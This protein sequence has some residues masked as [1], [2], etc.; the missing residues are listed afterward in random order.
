MKPVLAESATPDRAEALLRNDEWIAQQ[1][2]DGQRVLVTINDGNVQFLN[3]QGVAKQTNVTR[4][5]R[6]EFARF[7]IGEWAFDGEILD[8]VLWLFDMPRAGEHVD[9]TSPLA[10]RMSV[11]DGL[12]EQGIFTDSP[13]VRVLPRAETTDEKVALCE[14]VRDFGGEGLMLKNLNGRYEIGRR[15][16]HLLKYKFVNTCDAI[17]SRA[18]FDGKENLSLQ[19]Y[20]DGKRVDI[21]DC[22]ARAGDGLAI[23]VG[24]VVE[25]RYLY[26]GANGRLYQPTYPKIRDDKSPEEC[27]WDQ[28]VPVRKGVLV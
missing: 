3:R 14:K 19:V 13:V 8:G 21:G 18:G 27:T 1:K 5:M 16:R 9:P 4:P 28:L 12:V 20:R 25:V 23:K 2:V 7:H 24:D 10:W 15:S 6:D 17:V 22:T 26:L 11:L